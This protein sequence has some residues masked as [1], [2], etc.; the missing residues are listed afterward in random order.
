MS[1]PAACSVNKVMLGHSYIRLFAYCLWLCYNGRVVVIDTGWPA[2]PRVCTYLASSRN[3]DL[4]S[5]RPGAYSDGMMDRFGK[6]QK[7]AI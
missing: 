3:A 2:K 1:W 6:G 7:R 4:R 5:E